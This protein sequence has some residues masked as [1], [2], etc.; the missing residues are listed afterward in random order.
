MHKSSAGK[1]FVADALFFLH[2]RKTLSPCET[3]LKPRTK[4]TQWRWTATQSCL[5]SSPLALRTAGDDFWNDTTYILPTLPLRVGLVYKRHVQRVLK[6]PAVT[7][8]RQCSSWHARGTARDNSS[9]LCLAAV[10]GDLCW[11]WQRNSPLLFLGK[12]QS[13]LSLLWRWSQERS[14]LL[15][16][17]RALCCATLQFLHGTSICEEV[18]KAGRCCRGKTP[19]HLKK[20]EVSWGA[21]HT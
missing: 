12:D 18:R 13:H 2:S 5:K 7:Q 14:W 3:S 8:K 16:G 19:K 10:G 6:A 1:W 17:E 21:R 11:D 15:E 9:F 20:L 4:E